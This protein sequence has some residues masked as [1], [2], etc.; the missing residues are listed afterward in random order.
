MKIYQIN[1]DVCTLTVVTDDN[2]Q[3]I[4]V[5]KKE[6]Q[7]FIKKDGKIFYEYDPETRM[8]CIVEDITNKRGIVQWESH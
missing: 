7:D 5:L 3:L 8:E 6:D 1:F 2:E 4:D